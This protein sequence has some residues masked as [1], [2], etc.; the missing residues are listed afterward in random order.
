MPTH[1]ALETS[2]RVPLPGARALGRANPNA[3]IEVTLK[4]RRKQALPAL[5][6]APPEPMTRD[7]LAATHGASQ[8]DIDL[9]KQVFAQYDLATVSSDAAT[10][11]V[12]LEGSVEN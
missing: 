9:V 2:T 4:L 3:T 6:G 5:E 8:S 12:V 7:E 11:S 1:I 10:R